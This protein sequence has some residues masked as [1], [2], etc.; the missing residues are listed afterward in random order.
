MRHSWFGR[1]LLALALTIQVFSPAAANVA[2]SNAGSAKTAFQICLKSASD[3]ATGEQQLPGRPELHGGGCVFCR[4][5]CDGPAPIGAAVTEI[6]VAP[7][8]SRARAW[9][10]AGRASPT[11]REAS[12]RQP[13][14]PPQYS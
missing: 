14:A 4:L 12:W 3:F 11:P 6:R 1:L 9:T 2:Q 13:R 10:T 7:I 8:Q 5:S